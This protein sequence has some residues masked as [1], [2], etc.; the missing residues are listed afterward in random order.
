MER[1]ARALAMSAVLLLTGTA[2]T[3]PTPVLA[4]GDIPGSDFAGVDYTVTVGPNGSQQVTREANPDK[5]TH[6]SLSRNNDGISS[7]AGSAHP[8]AS[9][10]VAMLVPTS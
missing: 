6:L 1:R 9:R 10:T 8:S 4:A 7:G 2:L 3:V 5:F